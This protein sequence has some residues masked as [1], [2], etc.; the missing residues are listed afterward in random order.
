MNS[1]RRLAECQGKNKQN[2][3]PFGYVEFLLIFVI[4]V[5]KPR[6]NYT[7]ILYRP[8]YILYYTILYLLH[9]MSLSYVCGTWVRFSRKLWL[10][11]YNN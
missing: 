1:T 10:D 8:N 9:Y 7:C 2:E 11:S 6:P 4:F 3:T 5:I